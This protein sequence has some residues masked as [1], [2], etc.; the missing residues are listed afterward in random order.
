MDHFTDKA[1]YKNNLKF[2]GSSDSFV[3]DINDILTVGE[4]LHEGWM[5]Y[6]LGNTD[7][8]IDIREPKYRSYRLFNTQ[9]N[10]CDKLGEIHII[11]QKIIDGEGSTHNCDVTV[12]GTDFTPTS[13]AGGSTVVTYS[14]AETPS[15]TSLSPR[16]G[17]VEGG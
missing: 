3:S 9:A 10:G 12:S 17:T 7:L 4:E 15:I 5:Y 6:K 8:D 2:Q 11:G 1:V 16:W 14:I 13:T